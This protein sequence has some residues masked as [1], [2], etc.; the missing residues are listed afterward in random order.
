MNINEMDKGFFMVRVRD[1]DNNLTS[2]S[3]R[4]RAHHLLCIQGF[5]GLGYSKKFTKNMAQISDELLNNPFS[6]M[7]LVV[8]VDSICECCPHNSESVCSKE[9]TSENKMRIMD[10]LI[11]QTLNLEAG[12]VISSKYIPSLTRNLSRETVHEIC[13]TCYWRDNCLFFQKWL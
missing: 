10:S 4:I 6:F 7:E 8:G 12:S 1:A 9:P 5:Q 3:V 2:G 13:G 11:L